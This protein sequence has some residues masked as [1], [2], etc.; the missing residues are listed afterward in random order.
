MTHERRKVPCC[1]RLQEYVLAHEGKTMSHLRKRSLQDTL[2]LMGLDALS[3]VLSFWLALVFRFDGRIP[4]ADMQLLTLAIPVIA[5]IFVLA[6]LVLGLYRHVW[7]FTSS[8]E[9]LVI[10]VAAGSSTVLL[11]FA[12]LMFTVAR[13]VPISVVGLGG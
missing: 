1:R 4:A 3:V 5:G 6:N 13:P 2:P 12:D 7:R 9:V 10:G 11:T 8:N